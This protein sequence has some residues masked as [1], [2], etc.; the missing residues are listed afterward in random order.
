MIAPAVGRTIWKRA[1]RAGL[2]RGAIDRG[3]TLEQAARARI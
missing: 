1:V 3:A 2:E